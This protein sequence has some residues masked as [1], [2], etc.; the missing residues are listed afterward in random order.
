MSSCGRSSQGSMKYELYAV[1]MMQICLS[2]LELRIAQHILTHMGR[3]NT[4]AR[5]NE[6]ILLHHSS[7]GFDDLLFVIRDDF[8]T[9]L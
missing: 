7:C 9:F 2:G 5:D 6:I 1:Y 3:T 4:T 8:D